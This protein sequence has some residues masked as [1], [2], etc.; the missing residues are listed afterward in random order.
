MTLIHS[1][2]FSG[3]HPTVTGRNFL[4]LAPMNLV[5]VDMTLIRNRSFLPLK[6]STKFT[7]MLSVFWHHRHTRFR[8]TCFQVRLWG[9]PAGTAEPPL[10]WI[11]KRPAR[12]FH[13][14]FEEDHEYKDHFSAGPHIWVSASEGGWFLSIFWSSSGN[15]IFNED[16]VPLRRSTNSRD[17]EIIASHN[18]W[19][20]FQ[21]SGKSVGNSYES[22]QK[23]LRWLVHDPDINSVENLS[24]WQKNKLIYRDT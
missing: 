24:F 7:N 19:L 3:I 12:W 20:P 11:S 22:L 14:V 13:P 10:L 8:F 21:F 17:F 16:N 15:N 5:I 9:L 1:V 2:P 4:Q 6:P 18:V 23:S